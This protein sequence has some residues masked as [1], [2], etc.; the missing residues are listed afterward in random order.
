MPP[1]AQHHKSSG[2]TATVRVSRCHFV[3]IFAALR[4]NR[5]DMLHTD[6]LHDFQARSASRKVSL[7]AGTT[8]IL[9]YFFLSFQRDI[10]RFNAGDPGRLHSNLQCH[11]LGQQRHVGALER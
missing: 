5:H 6:R 1:L 9:C 4:I 10:P 2:T 8:T 3:E 7:Y 11:G